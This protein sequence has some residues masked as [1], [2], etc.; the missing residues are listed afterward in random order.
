MSGPVTYLVRRSWRTP[1]GL[2]AST[3]VEAPDLDG[4]HAIARRW[5]ADERRHHPPRTAVA[6]VIAH[7]RDGCTIHTDDVP[8]MRAVDDRRPPPAEESIARARAMLADAAKRWAGDLRGG[9]RP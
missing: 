4:A 1:D 6:I 5:A 3:S 8:V 7:Q 2:D 9:F